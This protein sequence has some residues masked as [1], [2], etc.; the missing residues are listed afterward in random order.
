VTSSRPTRQRK[1]VRPLPPGQTLFTPNPSPTRAAAERRSAAPLLFLHQIPG[2]VAPIVL[3][4]LLIAGFAIR[5]P[6]GGLALC[7]VAAVLA[8]LASISWPRLT[9]A[10]RAS[11][12]LA[13][14]VM[15]GL[16]VYQAAR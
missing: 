7:G 6:V 12:L 8:W 4:A 11:R 2:W 5:G 9:L 16:A 3:V 13:V 15:L 14:A 1:R 10:G